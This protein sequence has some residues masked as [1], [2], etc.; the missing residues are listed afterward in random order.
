MSFR[1]FRTALPGAES[2]TCLT[3]AQVAQLKKIYAGLRNSKGE[4]LFP[5]YMPGGEEGEDGWA[6]WITGSAPGQG[7]IFIFGLNYFRN[8]VFDDRAWDYRTVSAEHAVRMADQKTRT[9]YQC[10]GSGSATVQSPRR[11]ARPLSRLE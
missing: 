1:S 3:S 10:H 11:Q 2:E 8:M 9:N 7:G 6:G 4:Q 5:G